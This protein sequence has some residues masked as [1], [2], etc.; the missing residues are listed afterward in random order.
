MTISSLIGKVGSSEGISME[1]VKVA[2]IEERLL[3]T[4]KDLICGVSN[5]KAPNETSART[6][7][8]VMLAQL[9]I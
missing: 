3:E 2:A 7:S 5:T 6:L 1:A 9:A 8:R 4:V